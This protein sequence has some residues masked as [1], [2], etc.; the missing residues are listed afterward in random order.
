LHFISQRLVDRSLTCDRG[1]ASGFSTTT[2][3][4]QCGS[5]T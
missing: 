3:C 4:E 5:M 1:A 2:C